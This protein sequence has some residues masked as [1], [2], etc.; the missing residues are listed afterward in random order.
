MATYQGNGSD[1]TFLGVLNA[2]DTFKG[3]G[4]ND[5]ITGNAGDDSINGGSGNDVLRGGIGDDVVYGGDGNDSVTG[6]WGSDIVSGG[7]GDDVVNGQEGDDHIRGGVGNDRLIGGQ[8][9]DMFYFSKGDGAGKD[10]IVDLV[11]GEDTI[12]LE[13]NGLA[14]SNIKDIGGVAHVYLN[15]GDEIVILGH[16]KA[17]LTHDD[18]AFHQGAVDSYIF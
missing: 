7:T 15:N 11:H 6:G 10:T 4:G 17:D 18:F 12:V 5:D 9:D 8:G 14:I 16:S 13:G 1:E 3:A 2:D